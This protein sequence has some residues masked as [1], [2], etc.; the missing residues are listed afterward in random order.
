M[1]IIHINFKKFSYKIWIILLL[2]Y[3]IEYSIYCF[4]IIIF[5]IPY[6]IFVINKF[7]FIW[8]IKLIEIWE[9]LISGSNFIYWPLES[10]RSWRWFI[11]KF[12][13]TKIL[14]NNK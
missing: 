12:I 8:L 5:C 2:S 14:K 1:E 10:F 6:I 7:I 9:T 4:Y 13:I 3:I 11:T